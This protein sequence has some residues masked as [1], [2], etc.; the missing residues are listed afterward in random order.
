VTSNAS[1]PTH[2]GRRTWPSIAERRAADPVLTAHVGRLRSGLMLP[3]NPDDLLFREPARLHVHPLPGDG[4]YPFLEKF[5]GRRSPALGTF[6]NAS[7]GPA[8]TSFRSHSPSDT[9]QR[10]SA[11]RALFTLARPRVC[12]KIGRGRLSMRL[13]P[14]LPVSLAA[15]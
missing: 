4:L 10:M 5:S 3:Q 7:A 8:T 2:R 13:H 9:S 11:S 14:A 6:A 15:E 1:R 12:P